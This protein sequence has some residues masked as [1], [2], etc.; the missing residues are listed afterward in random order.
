MSEVV[1]VGFP[2]RRHVLEALDD[3]GQLA[4]EPLDLANAVAIVRDHKGELHILDQQ[5]LVGGRAVPWSVLWRGLLQHRMTPRTKATGACFRLT[6]TVSIP[7]SFVQAGQ[8][9]IQKG[10]SALILWLQTAA[11]TRVLTRLSMSGS[12]LI[13]TQL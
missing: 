3:I 11:P 7:T 8:E 2:N 6:G 9:L 1:I 5:Q 4:S 12:E 13:R 10:D